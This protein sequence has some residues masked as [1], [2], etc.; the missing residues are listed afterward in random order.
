[1]H[2]TSATPDGAASYH[3]QQGVLHYYL[4]RFSKS[5]NQQATGQSPSYRMCVACLTGCTFKHKCSQAAQNAVERVS[6][7]EKAIF[8]VQIVQAGWQMMKCHKLREGKQVIHVRFLASFSDVSSPEVQNEEKLHVTTHMPEE[9]I[10]FWGFGFGW[11]THFNHPGM[12][13]R[14]GF[15]QLIVHKWPLKNLIFQRERKV[16]VTMSLS[17][18]FLRDSDFICFPEF[19]PTPPQN[20]DFT[21]IKEVLEKTICCV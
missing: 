19:P 8:A 5:A 1:M 2:V 13:S 17:V 16:R 4:I 3:Q 7:L 9:L 11:V 15:S 10:V 18:T 12:A 6:N 14:C 20:L 21:Q